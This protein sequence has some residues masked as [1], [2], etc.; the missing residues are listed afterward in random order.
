MVLLTIAA[1]SAACEG[2]QCAIQ[3][4]SSAGPALL[5]VKS[6]KSAVQIEHVEDHMEDGME[7]EIAAAGKEPE[8]VDENGKPQDGKVNKGEETGANDE[9]DEED[10]ME[11]EMEDEDL[12]AIE[13][14]DKQLAAV[15]TESR[16]GKGRRG[17]KG[18]KADAQSAEDKAACPS[19]GR[20]V[21]GKCWHVSLPGT[22][23]E[24]TCV[25]KDLQYDEA[26]DLGKVTKTDH[27][28]KDKCLG[29]AAKLGFPGQKERLM[30][31]GSSGCG[32]QVYKVPA[33]GL[34]D[35]V[36]LSHGQTNAQCAGGTITARVC[37]CKKAAAIGESCTSSSGC[38]RSYCSC[39]KMHG[40]CMDSGTCTKL[41]A[42]DGKCTEHASCTT[43]YCSPSEGKCTTL[44]WKSTLGSFARSFHKSGAKRSKKMQVPNWEEM[45]TFPKGFCL[46]YYATSTGCMVARGINTPKTIEKAKERCAQSEEC[47]AVWCCATACPATTCYAVKAEAPNYKKKDCPDAP[48][49][50]HETKYPATYYT[51][52]S[53]GQAEQKDTE[54]DADEGEA[55]ENEEE[56]ANNDNGK[57]YKQIKTG[58]MCK[59]G[60]GRANKY[61]RLKGERTVDDCAEA[62]KQRNGLAFAFMERKKLCLM[63]PKPWS[64]CTMKKGKYD[65][66]EIEAGAGDEDLEQ[67]E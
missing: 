66:Y 47:K 30:Q 23:C 15:Q 24:E 20:L 40:M 46:G 27:D 41:L 34:G 58:A 16:A 17:G 42:P 10:D 12:E 6:A 21:D 45:T 51:K 48:G 11:E 18:K 39:S 62:V 31:W 59:F 63:P 67:A 60:R 1:A 13:D 50:F 52:D 56:S 49:S 61:T 5:Q 65:L 32:C 26:T 25:E 36:R 22:S 64:E 29:I 53:E 54:E 19:G 55:E 28:A 38:T 57:I 33:Y 37:A 44:A 9:D 35:E 2:E 3:D 4:A 8:Y 7:D 43:G 14:D